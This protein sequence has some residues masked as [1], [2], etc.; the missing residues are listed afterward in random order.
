MCYVCM[1]PCFYMASLGVSFRDVKGHPRG[2]FGLQLQKPQ[3]RDGQAEGLPEVTHLL[4]H[5]HLTPGG[6]TPEAAVR[7]LC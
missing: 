1:A 4:Q 7:A 3:P 6:P 5:Q 2:Y